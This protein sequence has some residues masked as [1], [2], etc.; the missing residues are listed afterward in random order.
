MFLDFERNVIIIFLN[1]EEANWYPELISQTSITFFSK[2]GDEI[3]LDKPYHSIMCFSQGREIASM[4][5][6]ENFVTTDFYVEALRNA[7]LLRFLKITAEKE[8]YPTLYT[9]VV[10]LEK[11]Q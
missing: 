5:L 9:F 8:K 7:D 6:K 1:I 2:L 4:P 11:I 3:T 10:S